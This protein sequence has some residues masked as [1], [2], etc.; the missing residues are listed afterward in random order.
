L[1]KLE[2][3]KGV[4]GKRLYGEAYAGFPRHTIVWGE[5]EQK[6]EYFRVDS[7]HPEAQLVI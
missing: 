4:L 5:T 6:L 1:R 2:T 3:P 7:E